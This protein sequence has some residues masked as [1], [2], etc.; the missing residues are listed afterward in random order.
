MIEERKNLNLV[1][2]AGWFLEICSWLKY[3]AYASSIGVMILA[4]TL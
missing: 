3:L 2:I 4:S 1:V